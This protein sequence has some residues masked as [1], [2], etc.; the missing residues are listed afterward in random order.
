[1]AVSR[2]QF[3][4]THLENAPAWLLEIEAMFI[5]GWTMKRVPKV[6][7]EK[8]L[9]PQL[10]TFEPSPKRGRRASVTPQYRVDR[11]VR[12]AE[13]RAAPRTEGSTRHHHFE[14]RTILAS[15]KGAI[16]VAGSRSGYIEGYNVA[17]GVIATDVRATNEARYIEGGN[18]T[19]AERVVY[20]TATNGRD[21]GERQRFWALANENAHFVGDHTITV[22]TSG[23]EQEWDRAA[24]D[25][26]MPDILREALAE[27][28]AAADGCATKVVNDAGVVK[29]WLKK[30]NLSFPAELRSHLT[31][32]TPHNGRIGYSIIGQFPHDMSH[33]GMRRSLDQLVG[34]FTAR[35][36]PCQAVI[37][38]PTAKNSKKNWHFHLIYYA[39]PAERLPNG[40]WSFERERQRDKW[41]TMKSVPLKRIG[42]NEEVAAVDWVPNLKKRWSEIVNA[43]ATREDI[44][45]RFTNETNQQRGLTKAQTR[46]TPG[47]QALH[48]Q[49]YFTD[50]EIDE[51]F[52]SWAGWQ[53]RMRSHLAS[54]VIA[55]RQTLERLRED[56]QRPG[57]G[58]EQRRSISQK[59]ESCGEML[60]QTDELADV[61]VRARKL[62]LMIGSGP[63]DVI[64]HYS[65]ISRTLEAKNS[66]PSRKARQSFAQ[67]VCASAQSYLEGHTAT[68]DRLRIIETTAYARFKAVYAKVNAHVDELEAHLDAAILSGGARDAETKSSMRRDTLFLAAIAERTL[69]VSEVG[70]SADAHARPVRPFFHRDML[71]RAARLRRATTAR[72]HASQPPREVDTQGQM[73]APMNIAR[74]SGWMIAQIGNSPER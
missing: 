30:R 50:A 3:A 1:M 13:P 71:A 9:A 25:A 29:R 38:E 42:R 47:R 74:K 67:R 8:T 66:T 4:G 14:Q 53:Q 46:Y 36:I 2:A 70:A 24:K 32:E 72:W 16:S 69:N 11:H 62:R 5:G 40:R 17:S 33:S 51:H 57:I 18:S 35:G 10:E 55:V 26:A 37:H 41:G 52:S 20:I 27:A 61:T 64:E 44:R 43:Q 48:K 34:E 28:K 65:G 23:V 21:Y 54:P 22:S 56:A 58:A 68:L 7:V 15:R 59:L 73:N 6:R 19:E 63:E 49:G 45:T 39:G 31:L 60:R 12:V